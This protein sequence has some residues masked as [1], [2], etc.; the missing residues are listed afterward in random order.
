MVLRTVTLNTSM[1][2]YTLTFD[3]SFNTHSMSLYIGGNITGNAVEQVES[4]VYVN[5]WSIFLGPIATLMEGDLHMVDGIVSSND[6][7]LNGNSLT[8]T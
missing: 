1:T 4:N 3:T 7:V 6:V 8:T 5:D 2:Y